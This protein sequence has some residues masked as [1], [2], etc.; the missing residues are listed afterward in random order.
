MRNGIE[1]PKS[2]SPPYLISTGSYNDGKK[3]FKGWSEI[4]ETQ[5]LNLL[6]K[7]HQK[8]INFALSNILSHKGK[9]NQQ[10]IEWIKDNKYVQHDLNFNYNV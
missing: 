9:S 8:Q 5:L 1:N 4:E 3:G 6:D 10:L 2:L 7:L